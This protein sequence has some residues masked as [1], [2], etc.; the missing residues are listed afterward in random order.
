MGGITTII[1]SPDIVQ[2]I[3]DRKDMI[4]AV[5]RTLNILHTK[6]INGAQ[7]NYGEP[8]RRWYEA[9]LQKYMTPSPLLINSALSTI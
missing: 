3:N 4:D 2:R 9:N 8:W 7:V 6:T 5:G 1:I